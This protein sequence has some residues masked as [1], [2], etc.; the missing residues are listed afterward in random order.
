MA[1]QRGVHLFQVSCLKSV[2]TSDN[3]FATLTAVLSPRKKF[4][5]PTE[6][7]VTVKDCHCWRRPSTLHLLEHKIVV[8]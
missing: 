4:D 5:S 8:K 7:M 6:E 3:M 1:K 2:G